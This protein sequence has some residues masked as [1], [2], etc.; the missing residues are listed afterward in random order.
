MIAGNG[1]A[2]IGIESGACLVMVSS[3]RNFFEERKINE[4]KMTAEMTL[5]Q[6]QKILELVKN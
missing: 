5:E 3:D 1:I 2:L 4:N 6:L